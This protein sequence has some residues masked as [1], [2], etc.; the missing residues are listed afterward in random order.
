MFKDFVDSTQAL[1]RGTT[2]EAAY[3]SQLKAEYE[4]MPPAEKTAHSAVNQFV[5][6]LLEETG[7]TPSWD[8]VYAFEMALMRL[9][10]V[11]KLRREAWS[12]RN[13]YREVTGEKNFADYL[14]SKACD[15]EIGDEKTLRADMEQLLGELHKAYILKQTCDNIRN[16]LLQTT[17]MLMCFFILFMIILGYTM[18]GDEGSDSRLLLMMVIFSG[19][20]G[21]FVSMQRRLQNDSNENNTH[22]NYFELNNGR[23]SVYLA[24]AS[25][26]I[27]AVILITIFAAKIISGELFP[28]LHATAVS[29]EASKGFFRDVLSAFRP[30]TALDLF[31]ALVWAFIAGFAERFVPDTLDRLVTRKAQSP[32][33]ETPTVQTPQPVPDPVN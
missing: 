13:R 14:N 23:L 3:F 26:A 1:I 11:E 19:A 21:G 6:K 22:Y 28:E 16:K 20:V 4:L 27:F 25:G 18:I 17:V 24:P 8:N 7:K 33:T 15:A 32:S 10:C 30:V 12:L 5:T 2:V 9:K 29:V 31:K